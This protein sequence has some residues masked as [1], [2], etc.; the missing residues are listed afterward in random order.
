MTKLDGRMYYV[1]MHQNTVNKKRYFGLTCQK[2]AYRW[3][4]GSAYKNNKPFYDDI[5]AFGWENF[6]HEIVAS[7]LSRIAAK[8][9]EQKLI[10]EFDSTNPKLGYNKTI[11][12]EG[13]LKYKTET[14][15]CEALREQKRRGN[16]KF[17]QNP[18]QQE[19]ARRYSKQYRLDNKNNQKLAI[20]NPEKRKQYQAKFW[21]DPAHKE[22]HREA[23][24]A[25]NKQQYREVDGLRCKLKALYEQYP[26]YF[27]SEQVNAV[28]GKKNRNYLVNSKKVLTKIYLSIQTQ[29]EDSEQK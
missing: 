13:H 3:G 12:G 11:G 5:E 27:A 24:K 28:F 22:K 6:T 15:R 4:R 18:E 20:N 14:E 25:S 19:K 9:L 1:Y 8:Q 17:M 16:R 10:A 29:L 2:P 21:S 23:H 26:A 7:E